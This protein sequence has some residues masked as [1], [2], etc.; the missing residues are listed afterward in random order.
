[1]ARLPS[2]L[3][4]AVPSVSPQGIASLSTFLTIGPAPPGQALASRP[5]QP[6]SCEIARAPHSFA[7]W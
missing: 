1:M 7:N 6:P 5:M 3:S 4:Q 2:D